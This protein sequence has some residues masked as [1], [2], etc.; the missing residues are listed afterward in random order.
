MELRNGTYLPYGGTNLPIEVSSEAF[1]ILDNS[2]FSPLLLAEVHLECRDADGI[3]ALDVKRKS[4]EELRVTSFLLSGDLIVWTL[5]EKEPKRAFVF[6]ATEF[7]QIR[8]LLS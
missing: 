6:L 5:T 7:S 8:P 4:I 2:R 3:G 1:D